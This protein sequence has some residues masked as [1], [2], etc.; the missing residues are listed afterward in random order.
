MFW[1]RSAD[2]LEFA[3]MVENIKRLKTQAKLC[4]QETLA[5]MAQCFIQ[6]LFSKFYVKYHTSV[7]KADV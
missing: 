5:N 4:Y 6:D 3:G 7:K 1:P 2:Y